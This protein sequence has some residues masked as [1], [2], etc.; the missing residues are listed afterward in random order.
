MTVAADGGPV[1]AGIAFREIADADVEPVVALWRDCGL[2]RPWNDPYRD[3]A[4][5]RTGETSTILVARDGGAVV[6]TVMA[7]LDGHRGWLYY[8]AVAP[9]RQGAGLGRAAVVAGEAWLAAQG[10][11]KVQLMVRTSNTEVVAFYERLGYAD[12]E[13]TVLGRWFDRS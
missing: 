10:A 8:V 4:D 12:Q 7:G 5:A 3:V 6:A 1:V 9:G 11:R 13:T 2:T